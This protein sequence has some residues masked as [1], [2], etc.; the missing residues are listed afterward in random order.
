MQRFKLKLD[1]AAGQYWREAAD[2]N[3]PIFLSSTHF[4]TSIA[5]A[6]TTALSKPYSRRFGGHFG[7]AAIIIAHHMVKRNMNRKENV[8]VTQDMRLFSDGGRGSGAIKGYCDIVNTQE[9]SQQDGEEIVHW[10]A[11]G[12]NIADL[13]PRALV[14]TGPNSGLWVPTEVDGLSQTVK[15]SLRALKEHRASLVFVSRA[16]AAG[17]DYGCAGSSQINRQRACRG[18]IAQRL[19]HDGEPERSTQIT[20]TD[21]HRPSRR[22]ACS[23]R[24]G[25]IFSGLFFSANGFKW[26]CFK[27]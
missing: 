23:R 19:D 2:A 22:G 11:F 13:N 7:K 6:G 18:A 24:H 12:K 25:R 17:L 1:L 10:G 27:G 14:Q 3:P 26:L 21:V 15:A 16:E 20:T 4:E 9:W 5:K 8:K